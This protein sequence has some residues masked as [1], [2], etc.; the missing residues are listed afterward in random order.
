M[1]VIEN[2]FIYNSYLLRLANASYH[3]LWNFN[4]ICLINLIFDEE[5][6]S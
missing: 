3:K 1:V 5:I 2:M 4:S 6:S